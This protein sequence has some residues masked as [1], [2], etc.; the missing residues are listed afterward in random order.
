MTM[1]VPFA[2]VPICGALTSFQLVVTMLREF[3]AQT[4]GAPS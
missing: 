3:S 1:V 2:S 4:E